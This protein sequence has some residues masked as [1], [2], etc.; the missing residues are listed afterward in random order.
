MR[1]GAFS[2]L[3]NFELRSTPFYTD[4]Q[5]CY[6]MFCTRAAQASH[7]TRPQQCLPQVY[8]QILATSPQEQPTGCHHP[9][10]FPSYQRPLIRKLHPPRRAQSGRPHVGFSSQ[11]SIFGQFD[12]ACDCHSIICHRTTYTLAL[13]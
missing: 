4:G 13:L 12:V 6:E 8:L 10:S 5:P 9:L 11:C 1:T 2:R 3:G 7:R